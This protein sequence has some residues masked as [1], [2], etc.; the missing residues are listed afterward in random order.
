MQTVDFRHFPLEAGD[1]V[2]DLGVAQAE[3]PQLRAGAL[4]LVEEMRRLHARIATRAIGAQWPIGD[5][6]IT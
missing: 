1:L 3:G 4:V 5:R 6:A 2:L